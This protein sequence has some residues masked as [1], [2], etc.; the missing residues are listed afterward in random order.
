MLDDLRHALRSLRHSPAFTIVALSVL[1]LA[2]GAGT[3]IF[4]VVDAVV[5]RGLPFDEHDRLV[6][7]LEHD[8]RRPT[9][10]GSGSTTTQM[11]S[12]WRAQQQSF[13]AITAAGTTR[14]E[15]TNE[16]G[17]PAE[18]RGLRVTH[19]F[20]TV[21]RV[22]P[23]LGR[24]FTARDEIFGQHR[25]VLLSHG[26]W[27]RRFGGAPDVAGRTVQMS[28][29]TFEIVGVMPAWFAYPVASDRPTE[30]Y[31]PIAFREED[32][33]RGGSRNYNFTAIGRLKDGVTLAQANDD[34]N[35][36]MAALDEQHPKWSP[37][38]RARVI[39][40][41]EH[42]VGR[43]RGWML[44][45]LAAVALVLLIAC[46]NVANLMLARATVRGR[47]VA[48][49]A[50]LGAGRWRLARGLLVEGL[51]LAFA[52]AGLG[53]LLA[54]LGVQ[55]L[56]AWMPANVPRVAGIAIDLRVLLTAVAAAGVTGL[57]FGA[58]PA[59]QSSKPNLTTALKD[60]GR[61][62]TAGTGS[63]R[64]RSLL[65]VA[66]VALAVV[67]LVGAGLFISSFAKLMRIDPGFDYRH[68]LVLDV[69]VRPDPKL[70]GRAMFDDMSKRGGPYI[71][72]VL[73]AVRAVP[74]VE[75][76]AAV[77][78]GLPLTGSWS[79][80]SVTLP[81]KGELQGDD[82][83][84]DRRVVSTDYLETMGIPLKRGRYLTGQDRE[85]SDKVVAIN[86]AA[87]RKY[88]PGEEALGK[89]IEINS[90]DMTVVGIV[91]DI[92]HLGPETPP[93][94]ECYVPAAQ[95]SYYGSATLVMRTSGDPLDR[96]A[97]VKTAIWAANKD[98]RL[99][100]ETVTLEAYM[101][102][103]IAQR[104]FN[105]ALLALFGI[106]GL[107]I[108]AAGIYGVMAYVVAQRTNEIGVRMAL[109]AT[110]RHVVGMVLVRACVLLG[111]GIAIGTAAAWWFSA[112]VKTFL[113]QVEPNDVRIFVA[114]LAALAA[115]GLLAS[116]VPARRAASVDPMIALRAE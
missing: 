106:L 13:E 62:S 65:V 40:L 47:E 51:V 115:A 77:Q 27:Q 108:A 98:Q 60:S 22:A 116:A 19:E 85:G 104:R 113:F 26:Y 63:Q 45:L 70:S 101:D 72:Q 54:Y 46:A 15:F 12:D 41:H 94:Q 67:L 66:E 103:L 50:A 69:G 5:L 14:F 100:T 79:R 30:M 34:M 17:E 59:L 107:V 55:A 80:S 102:R 89:R 57:I 21:M 112:G 49:R 28:D 23:L 92:R 99:R 109:G 105:M 38:R 25:V 93:R 35:R 3:A 18:A 52:A 68:V 64:L 87:A 8:T 44:M 73:A 33:V 91:G 20:F 97:A 71:E 6:A 90:Q 56:K 24:A 114:A 61:S 16:A 11:F 10:F 43:V 48:I 111:A 95:N 84:I 76:A 88:W 82:D 29:Q 53:I 78:G 1:A 2:I 9:T 81:G 32:K 74:G 110:R 83:S 75:A 86:E 58:V 36:L 96:L 39:T 31:V 42:L 4:S 37:G 7:V